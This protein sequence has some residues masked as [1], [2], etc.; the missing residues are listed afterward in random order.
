MVGVKQTKAG[1]P[2]APAGLRGNCFG[3]CIAS[4]L[5][6][7]MD[8]VPDLPQE[9]EHT[10]DGDGDATEWWR[11]YE[12]VL[13][14]FGYV[15]TSVK[16]ADWMPTFLAHDMYWIAGVPS[17]NLP[18]TE[19]VPDPLH[20]VVARGVRVAWDP[21]NKKTYAGVLDPDVVRDAHIFIA[22]DPRRT[23]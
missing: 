6:V 19:K 14:G 8:Q 11:H 2:D 22:I 16:A 21:S 7:G 4:V 3:A 23:T 18:P 15:M 17:L 9:L 13:G 10:M 20:A 5:E 1:G 12:R